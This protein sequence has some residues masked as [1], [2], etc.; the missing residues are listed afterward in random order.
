MKLI[1]GSQSGTRKKLLSRMG[2]AFDTMSADIDEMAI[3]HDDAEK[4]TLALARAKSDALLPK[5]AEDAILLTSDTVAECNGAILEK[6]VDADEVRRWYDLYATHPVRGVTSVVL[7]NTSTGKK[8]EGTVDAFVQFAPVPEE[9]VSRLIE[10]AAVFG[11]AG[12]FTM[13][14]PLLQGYFKW[15]KGEPEILQGMPIE[16]TKQLLQEMEIGVQ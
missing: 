8:V 4:L 13:D 5:V 3:R 2:Y 11:Y 6:A 12:A 14:D 16:L 7:V 15:T 10:N 9:V 1:L